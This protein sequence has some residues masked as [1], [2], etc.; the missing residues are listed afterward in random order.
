MKVGPKVKVAVGLVSVAALAAVAPGAPG[1]GQQRTLTLIENEKRATAQLIDE[2][3]FSKSGRPS[4]GDQIIFVT[5]LL[6]PEKRRVGTAYGRSTVVAAGRDFDHAS[7]VAEVIL[8]LR[9]GAIN[10]QGYLRA[11]HL[12]TFGI[13]GGTG[14]Y[15]GA[16]GTIQETKTGDIVRFTN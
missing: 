2:K 11:R 8:K 15:A 1:A 3:P 16:A 4:L 14:A 13:S 12:S 10:A 5:P 6:D 7:F 9:D